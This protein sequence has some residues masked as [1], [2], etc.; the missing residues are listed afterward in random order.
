MSSLT[1]LVSVLIGVAPADTAAPRPISQLVHTRWTPK[2]GGPSGV[3][4]IAQTRD[5][6]IWIGTFFGLMRFDGVRFV[7]YTPLSG[8]TLPGEE[9]S[10]LLATQDGSLWFTAGGGGGVVTRLKGGRAL[11]FGKAQGI[12]AVRNLTES[13]TGDLVA[14]SLYGLFQFSDGKWRNV[15]AEWGYPAKQA[16]TVFFDR[17]DGLWVMSQDRIF[18]RAPGTQ[19]FLDLGQRVTNA[20]EGCQF[21]EEKDGTIWFMALSGPAFTLSKPGEKPSPVTEIPLSLAAILF[22]RQGSLWAATGNDGLLRVPRVNRIRGQRITGAGPEA[23]RFAM[24]EGLLT[25]IPLALMEDREGNIWVGGPTGV[26]RFRAGAFAAI[27]QAGPGRPRYVIAGRDSSVWSSPYNL[28]TL[29]RL[30]PHSQ[31]SLQAG[32]HTLMV[33]QDSSGRTLIV[34]HGHRMI[35]IEG[36][37]LVPVRLR[38]GTARG[39]LNVAFDHNGGVWVFSSELG[40]LRQQGDSLALFDRLEDPYHH[41]SL[42]AD[43]QGRI[44]VGQANRVSLV[45]DGKVTRFEANEGIGGFVYGFFED[46][47]GTIWAGTGDGLSQFTG[48]RFRTLT[49]RQGIPGSNVYGMAQDDAGAWWLATLPG[50]LRFPPGE[51]EHVLADSTYT[52]RYRSFDETDGMVGALVKGY[53]GSV[54]TKSGDGR[55]WVATDSG[56]AVI[57]P[58]HLPDAAPPP[59]SLEVARVQGHDMAISEGNSLAPRTS[60]L[61]IDYTSLTFS[62]P[63]RVRFRYRLEGADST[64]RE[65]GTRRRAYYTGLAPGTYRFEVTASFEDG[66]WNPAAASWTF[67]VL[68]AWYQ[69][70]WFRALMVLLISGLGGAGVALV[71]RRRHQAEQRA[72]K[73]RYEATLVE[74]ARIAQDLHDTLLQGFAGV[75]LQ[76]KA[77]ELALPEQPDVAAETVLRAQR[78]AKA[79][80]REA[81]DRV[82]EMKATNPEADDLAAALES[83]ARD[84]TAGTGVTVSMLTRG[85]RRRLNHALEDAAFRIGR[86]AIVNAVRH[87]EATRIDLQVEFGKETLTVHVRDN[88]RGF[89]PMEGEA[90]KRNGHFGLSGVRERASHLGGRC[91]VISS[92]HQGTLVALELPLVVPTAPTDTFV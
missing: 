45:A 36:K 43:R 46:R 30:G 60:D 20:P 6:Y 8:D 90:A 92:P 47:N 56:L 73:E 5:G 80:L 51:I 29:Y 66:T 70:L 23:E 35:S 50:I 2:E 55:I 40:L 89:T 71:Q 87:A 62:T 58:A 77:I 85:E 16:R 72:L 63:E 78:L 74:R 69:T 61:E 91:E 13:S 27:S 22:D 75:T 12:S 57:D 88:G 38:P 68:P 64:W 18:Y 3:R 39:L 76:L 28:G 19:K 83:V 31:D 7:K 86:E 41:G 32:F 82:W 15:S 17:D 10:R 24:K 59:V 14:A 54:L 48:E 11:T 9:I 84:R 65:V 52:P 26:E 25:D 53:W 37:R 21:A 79:S 81:R 33:T 44:W 4:S 67:R 42:F 1:L 34:D 49:S